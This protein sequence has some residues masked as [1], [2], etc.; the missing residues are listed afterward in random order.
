MELII[1][2]P[3]IKRKSLY[4]NVSMNYVLILIMISLLVVIHDHDV[5][6]SYLGDY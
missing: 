1:V 3:Q 2:Q 6:V 4:C 5:D